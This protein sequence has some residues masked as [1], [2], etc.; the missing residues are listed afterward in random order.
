[1][2]PASALTPDPCPEVWGE[3]EL[4]ARAQRGTCFARPQAR[5]EGFWLKLWGLSRI[6]STWSASRWARRSS[7]AGWE[8]RACPCSSA[9]ADTGRDQI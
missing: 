5:V 6:P 1:M 4:G 9:A 2:A 8:P 7:L 3:D